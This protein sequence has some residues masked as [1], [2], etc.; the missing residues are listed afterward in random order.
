MSWGCFEEN[1]NKI[2]VIES[3][4]KKDGEM[5]KPIPVPTDKEIQK[6]GITQYLNGVIQKGKE[7]IGVAK[8]KFHNQSM[9]DVYIV[10]GALPL[11]ASGQ[12]VLSEQRQAVKDLVNQEGD[13]FRQ[14]DLM[15]KKLYKQHHLLEGKHLAVRENWMKNEKRNTENDDK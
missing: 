12:T 8:V 2:A 10:A 15:E 11:A 13:F 7:A 1:R 14:R 6:E 9:T 4:V 3:R 5:P